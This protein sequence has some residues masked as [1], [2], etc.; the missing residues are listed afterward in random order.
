MRDEC[1]WSFLEAIEEPTSYPSLSECER[2]INSWEERGAKLEV[3]GHSRAGREIRCATIGSGSRGLLAWGFPHPDEP[4]GAAALIVL[5][6]GLLSGRLSLPDWRVHLILCADPDN[7]ALN[8]WLGR[9]SSVKDFVESC[10]RPAS[11]GVEVDYGFALDHPPFFSSPD[12]EG[13]CRSKEECLTRCGGGPC[14]RRKLPF[15]P[16]PESL[17]LTT[18]LERYRPQ[19]VAS[20][21]SALLGGDY[22]FLLQRES[23]E[24]LDALLAIPARCGQMR[25]LGEALDRG[26]RWRNGAPDLIREQRFIETIR[27]LQRSHVYKPGY[28]YDDSHSAGNYIEVKLP[29]TQFICPES[30]LFRHPDFSDTTPLAELETVMVSVEDRPAGRRRVIT[31]L[32]EGKW[33]IVQLSPSKER[34]SP[35]REMAIAPTRAMLGVRAVYRRRAVLS[36]I[37]ELWAKVVATGG[38][39]K[40]PYLQERF[41]ED[42]P[43][44]LTDGGALRLFLSAERF[45]TPATK[46]QAA[47]FRWGWPLETAGRIG[48]F[49]NFLEAQ[50]GSAKLQPIAEELRKLQE[51]ELTGMPPEISQGAPIAPAIRS[52]LARVLTLAERRSS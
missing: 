12:F 31:T 21:H 1:W 27:Q 7:V 49:L 32:V 8:G 10:W 52:Q 17:A 3:L 24:T 14:K 44:R 28:T 51:N 23:K 48:N 29:E 38:L 34:V 6:E 25:H 22:T 2:V 4:I 42:I 19:L 45:H 43:G 18:A 36:R 9:G 26:R 47:S 16:L 33:E 35:P 39:I 46:A 15:A 30:C 37:D 11:M 20:M 5:G 41:G 40:H 13:R 50:S